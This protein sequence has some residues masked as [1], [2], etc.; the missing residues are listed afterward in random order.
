MCGV[1][2]I[3]YKSNALKNWSVFEQAFQLMKHR[4]PD[5]SSFWKND[6]LGLYHHRLAIIDLSEA[7]NQPLTSSNFVMTYNGEIYNYKDIVT[8]KAGKSYSDTQ[9]LFQHLQRAG[10]EGLRDLNGIFSFAFYD[11]KKDTLLLARDR[12]GVKPLYYTETEHFFAFASE[13]K[14]FYH[15]LPKI[16]I[17]WSAL[18]EFLVHGSIISNE[19]IVQGVEKLSPGSYIELDCKTFIKNKKTFWSVE[20]DIVGKHIRKRENDTYEDAKKKTEKLILSGVA[21][22]CQSDVPIGAYLSGGIDS[23]LVVAMASQYTKTPLKTFS[24]AFEGSRNS[25]LPLAKQVAKKYHTE[26][27]EFEIST[28][29]IEDELNQIVYQYDDPFADPAIIPLHLMAKACSTEAKVVLQGDG[30]D[31]LYGGYGRHLDASELRLRQFA[32]P[33]AAMLHPNRDRRASFRKRGNVITERNI[34]HRYGKMVSGEITEKTYDVLS[35]TALEKIKGTNPW[36]S[37]ERVSSP[38]NS[39]DPLQQMLYVDMQVILPYTF[40]EKVDKIN[41]WHSIEARVPLLDND[42]VDYVMCLPAKYKIKKR[43]TKYLL[44]DIAKDWLP[45]QVWQGRKKSFGT[46]MGSWLRTILYDYVKS[47][48]SDSTKLKYSPLISNYLLRLLEDHRSLKSD[49]SSILWRAT[50]LLLWWRQYEDKIT[51]QSNKII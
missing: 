3:I 32:Y 50:V 30:G 33:L 46:P 6:K 44:R 43:S 1:A 42:V 2:G 21:R 48:F 37:Y 13:A 51:L 27:H 36:L 26:H 35:R 12:L 17:N 41:M 40:M 11:K 4:G 29:H 22:Q 34:S 45:E 25:E 47:V 5:N 38:L 10:I 24:A 20:N 14:V 7:S 49:H 15:L 39:L 28:R 9:V 19:N 23:S 18:H 31:E 16:S 8:P